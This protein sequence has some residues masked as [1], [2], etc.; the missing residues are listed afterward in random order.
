M[1]VVAEGV[2]TAEQRALLESLGCDAGQGYLFSKPLDAGTAER[3]L[4]GELCE[5]KTAAA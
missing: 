5:Q 3:L 2:E 1:Q 4:P